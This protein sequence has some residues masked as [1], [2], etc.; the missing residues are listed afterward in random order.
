MADVLRRTT[1]ARVKLT[2]NE[3]GMYDQEHYK[4]DVTFT[5]SVH[6][7]AVLATNM[8]SMS[9][10]DITNVTTGATTPAKVFMLET[11][12]AIDVAVDTSSNT[13]SLLDNGMVMMVGSF[14]HVYVQNNNT[15]YKATIEFVVTD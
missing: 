6:Q 8:T 13:L 14:T 10:L 9:E 7:R 15:T 2:K 3:L 1:R 4:E 5:E 12:R 11:D